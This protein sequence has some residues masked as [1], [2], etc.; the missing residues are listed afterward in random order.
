MPI[1]SYN[2]H[3]GRVLRTFPA[4]TWVKTE[5]ILDQAHRAAAKWQTTSFAH[6]ADVLR[7]AAALLRERQDEPGAHHG[8][9]NGQA[10][11]R[12]PRRGAEVRRLL[13]VLRRKRRKIPGR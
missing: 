6:R 11:D 3:T 13:R 9:G 7:A 5:R 12:R 8:P 10:R 4:F 2:P 1:E